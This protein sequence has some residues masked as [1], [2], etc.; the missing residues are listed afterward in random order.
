MAKTC[1]I[2]V[3]PAW[4]AMLQQYDVR[5]V[6]VAPDNALASALRLSRAWKRIYSDPVA[7][8]YERIS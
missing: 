6:L 3:R 7:A 8:V 1:W 2:E 4:E 5:F